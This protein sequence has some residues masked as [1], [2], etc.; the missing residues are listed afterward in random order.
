MPATLPEMSHLCAGGSSES[1]SVT[2]TSSTSS[3][4]GVPRG[5]STGFPTNAASMQ[6]SSWLRKNS[7]WRAKQAPPRQVSIGAKE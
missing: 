5:V 4:S 3:V 2:S 6:Q 1:E 7:A